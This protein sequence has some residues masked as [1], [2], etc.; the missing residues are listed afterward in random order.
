MQIQEETL[1]LTSK[2]YVEKAT[3][4][5]ENNDFKNRQK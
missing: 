2:I 1:K 5:G 3:K 4:K